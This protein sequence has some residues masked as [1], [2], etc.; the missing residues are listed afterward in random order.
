MAYALI[1]RLVRYALRRAVSLMAAF[2]QKLI[3]GPPP[4]ESVEAEQRR[5]GEGRSPE[6]SSGGPAWGAL[7]LV[8]SLITAG[9]QILVSE[10]KNKK[11]PSQVNFKLLEWSGDVIIYA[12]QKSDEQQADVSSTG[13][14]D[15]TSPISRAVTTHQ[16]EVSASV[17]T[18][19]F[20]AGHTEF[21]AVS[22]FSMLSRGE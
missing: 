14:S 6:A 13:S 22:F 17:R 8:A 19:L 7:R 20:P 15:M 5:S 12:H 4:S 9:F 1:S 3:D 21:S 18:A 10:D 11:G 16:R 2:L